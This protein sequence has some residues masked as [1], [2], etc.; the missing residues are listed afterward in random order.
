[1]DESRQRAEWQRTAAVVCMVYNVMTD[2][3]KTGP[4]TPE[5]VHELA[6]EEDPLASVE[7]A[8]DD[9]PGVPF[10]PEDQRLL[11]SVFGDRRHVYKVKG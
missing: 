6:R 2:T 7:E 4:L 10:K 9:A 11:A 8:Q 1:M 5:K 3:R